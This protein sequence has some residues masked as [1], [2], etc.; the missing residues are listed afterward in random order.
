M[1]KS[2]NE[3]QRIEA[4]RDCRYKNGKFQ[5]EWNITPDFSKAMCFNQDISNWETDSLKKKKK[6]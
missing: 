6:L 2:I 5:D 1:L 3:D 4:D